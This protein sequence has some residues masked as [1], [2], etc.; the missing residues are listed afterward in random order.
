MFS[1]ASVA[2]NHSSVFMVSSVLAMLSPLTNA[3]ADMATDAVF[4]A[5][6]AARRPP[7]TM[8]NRGTASRNSETTEANARMAAA[9]ACA[10]LRRSGS[11][12]SPTEIL[13]ASA[14]E[15]KERNAPPRPPSTFR[16]ASSA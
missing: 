9:A 15:E 2:T 7:D 10:R 13:T 1:F 6:P 4:A 12:A 11:S 16:A 8:A 14:A 5:A 3:R